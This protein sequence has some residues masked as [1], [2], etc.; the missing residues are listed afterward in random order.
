MADGEVDHEAGGAEEAGAVSEASEVG[1]AKEVGD[2]GGAGGAAEA[3]H[4]AARLL[5]KRPD[6]VLCT[7]S[8]RVVGWPF[9]SIAPYALSAFGE[10][11]LFISTIAEHTKNIAADDRVSLLIRD[12]AEGGDAQALGRLTVM[13][14]ASRVP[15][16]QL[17]DAKARYLARVPSASEYSE[18]H[19][20]AYYRVSLEH[21]RYIGGFGQI[22]W[23]VPGKLKLDPALDPLAKGA[24]AI[25]DHMNLDHADALS[26][27]CRAFKGVSPGGVRMIGVD[28]F[29]FDVECQSPAVRLRFDFEEPARMETIRAV[30]VKMAKE[31]RAILSQGAG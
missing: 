1:E 27:Y 29:G 15:D 24:G 25:I 20:F 23:L 26:N 6:A 28:Q 7:I 2:A 13:G 11:I 8:K 14:R 21:L 30:V 22:F 18:A 9:G 31:A 19:D 16:G 5:R 3:V 17:A 12:D 4:G 10:P